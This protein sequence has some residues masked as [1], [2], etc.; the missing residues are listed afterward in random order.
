MTIVHENEFIKNKR[1]IINSD[2]V[3]IDNLEENIDL[4]K[5]KTNEEDIPKC[6]LNSI[7]FCHMFN[8]NSFF[9]F[10]RSFYFFF[11]LQQTS[12]KNLHM[13]SLFLL[14]VI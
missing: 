2:H 9:F 3:S 5:F 1:L 12:S 13:P 7:C 14:I 4:L 10:F 8:N 11:F 6:K